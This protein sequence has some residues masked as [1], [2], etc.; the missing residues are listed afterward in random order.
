MCFKFP[1][2]DLF[3]QKLNSK[4]KL[5]SLNCCSDGTISFHY[6][7]PNEILQ[8]KE[9]LVNLEIE[10]KTKDISFKDILNKIYN[11]NL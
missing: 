8:I 7:K 6:M 5:K 4:K 9:A 2:L 11:L 10:K 3:K 1:T